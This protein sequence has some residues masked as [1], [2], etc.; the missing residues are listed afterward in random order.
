MRRARSVLLTVMIEMG[1]GGGPPDDERNED[2]RL[3]MQ[4]QIQWN[5]TQPD[6]PVD[7]VQDEYIVQVEL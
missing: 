5:I 3:S 4:I 2:Q 7:L 1:G 6:H